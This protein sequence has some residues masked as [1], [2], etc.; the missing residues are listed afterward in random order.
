ILA[1]SPLYL[2]ATIHDDLKCSYRFIPFLKE[3]MRENDIVV[4]RGLMLNVLIC[5]G[6]PPFK[7]YACEKKTFEEFLAN[8]NLSSSVPHHFWLCYSDYTASEATI[9]SFYYRQLVA[10]GAKP[11]FTIKF[12]NF[13]LT[14]F[15]LCKELY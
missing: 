15:S 2:P 7:I 11:K 5:S 4:S 13:I 1:G 9:G 10:D 12:D 14:Y 8:N 3:H 6:L